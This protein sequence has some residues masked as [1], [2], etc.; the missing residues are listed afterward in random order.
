MVQHLDPV[1]LNHRITQHIPRNSVKIFTGLHRDLEK[2]P[3]PHFLNSL[4]A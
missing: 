4:M 3:L 2:F 1:I